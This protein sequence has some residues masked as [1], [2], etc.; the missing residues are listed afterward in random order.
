MYL[1]IRLYFKVQI[2]RRYLHLDRE[3]SYLMLSRIVKLKKTFCG[4][5]HHHIM[6]MNLHFRIISVLFFKL[7]NY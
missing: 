2:E 3:S 7:G 1:L 6:L 4:L 5:Y